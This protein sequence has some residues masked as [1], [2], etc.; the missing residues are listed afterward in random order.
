[1]TALLSA[2]F[3]A[4]MVAT[5]NPCGF[6]MLPAYLGFFLS[7]GP[8]RTRRPV[9]L[10]AVAVSAGF[11][12]VFTAAGLLVGVGVR[13][14]VTAIPWL[15]L[16]VG[17]AL[18][19]VGA[20][21]I[22]G[23]RV[24]PYLPGPRRVRKDLSLRGMFA[25]GVSYAVASLSCTL[26]IFLSLVGGAVTART[27][28]EAMLAF[29]AYGIGMATVVSG[30][31]MLVAAGRRSLIERV[32]SIARRIDAIAG[33]TMTI[34]GSFIVWYWATVLTSGA[35]A[36]SAHRAVRWID[37]ASAWVTGIVGRNAIPVA[38]VLLVSAAIVYSLDRRGD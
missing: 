33:W 25:F 13:A 37:Q 5:V 22:L 24:L 21:Q 11:L 3:A 14:V 26:P 34:A 38:V 19:V 7:D 8:G 36:L 30:S 31:T 16:A 18:V 28:P 32:R 10:V 1:M 9:G 17:A 23:K 6:A 12:V 15:A 29:G 20:A 2:A 27:V 35:V 4:G